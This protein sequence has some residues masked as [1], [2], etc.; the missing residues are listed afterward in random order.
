[1]K[2]RKVVSAL[3]SASLP[4]T[5]PASLLAQDRHPHKPG[6]STQAEP[7]AQHRMMDHMAQM[8]AEMKRIHEAKDPAEREKLMREHVKH[9]QEGMQMMR[10]M[11]GQHGAGR[12]GVPTM[13]Q[14]M[15]MM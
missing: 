4:G 2:A 6:A 14:R 11:G 5:V 3:I 15:E 1:M 13:E 12:Q 10:G 9:V 8:Q 7:K